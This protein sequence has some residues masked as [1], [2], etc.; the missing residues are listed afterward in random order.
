MHSW[1]NNLPPDDPSMEDMYLNVG[2]ALCQWSNME[3]NLCELFHQVS[4]RDDAVSSH[5]EF[6]KLHGSQPRLE[7]LRKQLASN[8]SGLRLLGFYL[9]FIDIC[10][11]LVPIRNEIA[12]GQVVGFHGEG[13][14]DIVGPKR[15]YDGLQP[16]IS[17]H[18][19]LEFSRYIFKLN[20][21]LWYASEFEHKSGSA[22]ETLPEQRLADLG[23]FQL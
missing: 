16:F 13:V 3:V 17:S 6:F 23:V 10:I 22:D 19:V 1:F 12:H 18:Q 21:I 4:G 15:I 14:V 5:K 11:K 8:G 7:K 2:R 20:H 9:R